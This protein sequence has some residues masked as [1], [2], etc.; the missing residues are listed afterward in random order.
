M[1]WVLQQPQRGTGHAVQQAE[2]FLRGHDGL[3]AGPLRRRAA[4]AP[5]HAPRADGGARPRGQCRHRADR[6]RARPLRLRPD[7]P[8]RRG[9]TSRRSS[10]TGTSPRRSARSTRST[11]GSTPSERPTLL[12]SLGHLRDD[13]QQGELYLTDTIAHLRA[14][15]RGVGTYTLA[16]PLEI[17]GHQHARAARRRR[18]SSRAAPQDGDRGLPDLRRW[19]R[20][21]DGYP[22]LLRTARAI[23]VVTPCP[24]NSGQIDRP[25]PPSRPPPLGSR[26]GGAREISGRSRET[27]ASTVESIYHPQGM[28]IGYSSGHT[29]GTP[30]AP[31]HSPL[32]RRLQLPAAPGRDEAPARVSRDDISEGAGSAR[33]AR[34]RA[35]KGV[36]T[37]TQGRGVRAAPGCAHGS[38]LL[39]DRF[40]RGQH[41]HRRTTSPRKP[42]RTERDRPACVARSARARRSRTPGSPTVVILNGCGRSGLGAKVE[43]WLRRSGIDVFETRNADKAN[44]TRRIVVA[45]SSRAEAAEQVEELPAEGPSASGVLITER[46]SRPRGGR[47]PDPRQGLPRFVAGLLRCWCSAGRNPSREGKKWGTSV[48]AKSWSSF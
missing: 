10:R 23:L 24:Y 7:H 32:D 20:R 15:G 1:T 35:M 26:R 21:G 29:G 44:T 9:R 40:L 3:D 25:P 41:L 16:D 42:G 37:R 30:R 38:A 18:G 5:S 11:P 12:E 4:P 19:R 36:K 31:G 2:P 17:S 34:D 13:N 22:I 6:A 27:A 28:N 39:P 48:S 47:A 46:K 33:R 43:R 45:R 8:R 14:R